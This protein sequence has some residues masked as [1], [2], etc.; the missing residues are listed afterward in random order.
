M[1]EELRFTHLDA[2]NALLNGV[3]HLNDRIDCGDIVSAKA[4]LKTKALADLVA[5]ARHDLQLDGALEVTLQPFVAAGGWIGITYSY[6]LGAGFVVQGS[7]V[8]RRI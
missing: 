2:M 7:P 3:K 1:S 4:A 8:P 6:S 5:V